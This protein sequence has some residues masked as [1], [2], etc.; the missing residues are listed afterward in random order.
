MSSTKSPPVPRHG[1][2]TPR[3]DSDR[4]QCLPGPKS[5]LHRHGSFQNGRGELAHHP[6]PTGSHSHTAAHFTDKPSETGCREGDEARP[7][8]T[9]PRQQWGR[10]ELWPRRAPDH[11]RAPTLLPL[12]EGTWPGWS[13][14]IKAHRRAADTGQPLPES[15]PP[16]SP[17][18]NG[19]PS[20]SQSSR[21]TASPWPGHDQ[22]CSYCP[23][24]PKGAGYKGS[25]PP[26]P[27][28]RGLGC[29]MCLHAGGSGRR[30]PAP[31][32]NYFPGALA[33]PQLCS[34]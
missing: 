19:K 29:H 1:P 16:P 14:F 20:T 6:V 27:R 22:G 24:G 5:A 17:H 25:S 15:W 13:G 2:V 8:H 26:S 7:G 30:V 31:A 28:H 34:A 3:S 32:V 10:S 12:K 21:P 23:Q 9:R 4:N 33:N 18:I 11:D